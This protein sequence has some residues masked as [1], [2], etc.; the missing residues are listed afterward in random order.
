MPSKKEKKERIMPKRLNT[1]REAVNVLHKDSFIHEN[2]HRLLM[3]LLDP[4]EPN[5]NLNIDSNIDDLEV[6]RAEIPDNITCYT[7]TTSAAK[8]E[9]SSEPGPSCECEPEPSSQ[10]EPGLDC[11]A[12]D[13][14]CDMLSR[15]KE[16]PEDEPRA[17][18][19]D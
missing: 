16:N 9:P 8:L 11:V 10:S 13:T 18:D 3:R 15:D 1:I 7:S 17:S 5:D 14:P 12:H 4:N 6:W 19:E 2:V